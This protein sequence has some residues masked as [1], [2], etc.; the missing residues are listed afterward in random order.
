MLLAKE[1]TMNAWKRSILT[2]ATL[3]LLVTSACAGNVGPNGLSVCFGPQ[4]DI[5]TAPLELKP[6]E[7]KSLKETLTEF[8]TVEVAAAE[9]RLGD[10]IDE[11]EALQK[12]EIDKL[13]DDLVAATNGGQMT[14]MTIWIIADRMDDLSNEEYGRKHWAKLADKVRDHIKSSIPVGVRG[15]CLQ[16]ANG[17]SLNILGSNV[18]ALCW[19]GHVLWWTTQ[20]VPNTSPV[21]V[22]E[23]LLKQD[24]TKVVGKRTVI[25][26]DNKGETYY[27]TQPGKAD[28]KVG[29]EGWWL[30]GGDILLPNGQIF[31][32][33]D[34]KGPLP[35][36]TPAAAPSARA[37]SG[38]QPATPMPE[39]S[40]TPTSNGVWST[41]TPVPTT[42]PT[43]TATE[44]ANGVFS[45]NTPPPTAN[46]TATPTSGGVFSTNTP[47]PTD[48][49]V[50]P[51]ATATYTAVPQPSASPAATTA[52]ASMPFGLQPR[53]G[54]TPQYTGPDGAL[55]F[56]VGDLIS[57]FRIRIGTWE[58]YNGIM[59]VDGVGTVDKGWVNPGPNQIGADDFHGEYLC[60]R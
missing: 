54:S 59:M 16:A 37:T 53:A 47:A 29:N 48:T 31:R 50:P 60:K 25:K 7:E 14:T 41:N 32:P 45:T 58:C 10:R 13:R 21:K 4:C 9:G 15:P 33:F 38:T 12:Q 24:V 3:F 42:A 11:R 36:W 49:Q 34:E 57:G 30:P 39:A 52:P 27:C 1:A 19:G 17:W 35:T 23:V 6:T 44:T 20:A 5:S 28:P 56:R 18:N 22:T 46:P 51:A 43:A 26:V 8:L 40:K 55:G 2:I